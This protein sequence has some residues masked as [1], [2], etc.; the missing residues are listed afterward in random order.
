[1]CGERLAAKT[2]PFNLEQVAPWG[3]S[4]RQYAAFFGLADVVAGSQ[5]LDCAAGPSSFNAELTSSS[6]RVISADPLYALP[7][8][9]IARRIAA[10]REVMLS[11]L[12]AAR[13][14]FLWTNVGTPE[15]SVEANMAAMDRFLGDFDAGLG[16]QRYVAAALPDL[17]FAE[18]S[19]DLVL[20][21]H[22]LFLYSGL[23]D[24]AFHCAALRAMARVG[25]EVRVFPLLDLDGQKS[26]HLDAVTSTLSS[27]GYDLRVRAVG[28]EFQKGGNEMLS[29]RRR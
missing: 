3:R 25:R 21:S 14:R 13:N 5:I 23:L 6:Y 27:E 10:A 16:E 28:Y 2:N 17:P 24:A 18:R 15:E 22:F 7:K 11:G 26:C 8:T 12:R 1:M 19:F 4:R 20:C 9:E 29:L